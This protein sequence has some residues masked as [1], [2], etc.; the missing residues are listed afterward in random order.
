MISNPQ[1]KVA[2]S[3]RYT[4]ERELGAGGMA[5]VYLA[6]DVRHHR[7]VALKVLRPELSAI[8]GAERFL[9]EI[10][11]TA[12]LQHPHILSLFD[13]GEADGTVFYVMPY[14]EG[15][16]LRDRIRREQQLP[17]DEAVRI[18]R[19]V[20]DALQYAHERGIVHRDI[21][22][23]NILLHGGHAMVADFGIALAASKVDGG[24]R[25]TETGMS[26]GTPQYMSP[27]QAMGERTITG[28]ADVY[29]L[30]CVLYEMLAGEPPFT[31]GSA[32][33]V[34]ARVL[35][36]EPRSLTLQRKTIPPHV[37]AAVRTALEKL[38]ADRFASA[39]EFAEA[40]GRTDYLAP[41]TRTSIAPK[42]RGAF[43]LA[44]WI[45]LAA[46]V[47]A[48]A[49]AYAAG[50]VTAP[51]P[52][53]GPVHFTITLPESIIA[54]NRCCGPS[55]ALSPDG[56]TLVFVGV[57]RGGASALYR[58]RLGHLESELIPGTEEG[59]S[60]FF[61][62]DGQWLGF[63][64]ADRIRKGA[65]SGGPSTPVASVLGATLAG[66]SW[67]E[68][69][70]IVYSQGSTIFTV[71]GGGGSPRAVPKL[72]SVTLHRNPVVLPGAR[73][74]LISIRQLGDL[75]DA[76]RMGVIDLATGKVDTLGFGVRAEYANDYLVYGAA[77]GTLLAQPFNASRGRMTGAATVLVD[78]VQVSG[79]Q[80]PEFSLSRNGW[81]EYM[82]G[83]RDAGEVLRLA[84]TSGDSVMT[85]PGRTGDNLEDPAISPDGRHVIV[86]L[87]G[88]AVGLIGDLWMLDRQQGTLTRFTVGGGMSPAWSRDGRRVAYRATGDST[89]RAGIYVRA[90]DQT[91]VP[92]LL[93]AGAALY[94]ASWL[95]GDRQIAF[96]T[97]GRGPIA[98]RND[99]GLITLGDTQPRWILNSEFGETWPQVSKDGRLLAYGSDRT[100]RS[101]IYVLPMAENSAPTQVSIEGGHSPRWGPDGRTLYYV[102]AGNVVA[103]TLAPGQ[104]VAVASRRVVLEGRTFDLNTSN[105]NW[106]IFPDGKL[107]YIDIGSSGIPRIALIQ[108]WPEMLRA[109][110]RRD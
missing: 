26:L 109:G 60:P 94:P 46:G 5:T 13:S 75:I 42:E 67:G 84:S 32:Q 43:K 3:G 44:G 37:E 78:A 28:R 49:G 30:G 59:R 81:L 27:E 91:G 35:T 86:R 105:V 87:A 29:A 1:L 83:G 68:N 80:M 90:A 19:E 15:E 106:D 66:V 95:P 70:V 62:P 72:D 93:L 12:N 63:V 22:P 85:L 10:K 104:G 107:L 108:N 31:G 58:R 73:R 101:E 36:D 76:Q 21:K 47:F 24:T 48:L 6:H 69:D 100:G 20:L 33:A 9:A 53:S 99:I 82:P 79:G 110:S 25:M 65:M 57:R 8:L 88:A 4:I 92:Q 2:L 41:V 23:E 34:F 11:T 71:P 39:R 103:A 77:D 7:K 52:R 98:S 38:P 102:Q 97:P 51:A 89:H 64:T 18:A 50:R 56:Q 55:Q 17:I 40:L 54:V 74:A 45:A 96:A 14:V 16:S 61:S